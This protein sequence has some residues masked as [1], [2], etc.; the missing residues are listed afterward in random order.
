M[1]AHD[2]VESSRGRIEVQLMNIVQNINSR[3][4]RFHHR[5]RR[6][7]GGPLT[8]I[9]IPANRYHRS[10]GAQLVKYFG[11]SDIPRVNDE[12]ASLER[13]Q[14]LA[15]QQAMGIGNDADNRSIIH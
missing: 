12:V 4:T 9:N 14:S 6:Q 3:R 1:P 2:N 7:P 10:H 13:A 8:R 15:P 5:S 11:T